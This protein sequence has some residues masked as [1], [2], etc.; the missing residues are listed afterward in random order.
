MRVHDAHAGGRRPRQVSADARG[1][2]HHRLRPRLRPARDRVLPGRRA[3]HDLPRARQQPLR[4]RRG[5]AARRGLAAHV[6][7]VQ[8]RLDHQRRARGHL[9][10]ALVAARCSTATFPAGA[11]TTPACAT[12][13]ASRSWSSGTRTAQAKQALLRLRQ[14]A[15]RRGHGPRTRS[16]S[17]SPGAPPRTSAPTC[18]SA[19]VERLLAIHDDSGLDSRSIYGGKAHPRD[20]LGKDL[21]RTH[22]RGEATKLEGP[23]H[24]SSTSRTTTWRWRA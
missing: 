7:P 16:P 15:H 3:E 6:R 11:R 5:E 2:R 20:E 17:A 4:Q 19:N 8:D 22:L 24:A 21:I 13:W 1:A 10:G 14:P 9:G 23:D 18:C 12:R